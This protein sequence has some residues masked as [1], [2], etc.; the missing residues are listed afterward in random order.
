MIIDPYWT[1]VLHRIHIL[2]KYIIF[3][4][5]LLMAMIANADESKQT[6]SSFNVLFC[7][8]LLSLFIWIFLPTFS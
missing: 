2:S 1:L 4:C 6:P 8:M 7:V 3:M 5:I